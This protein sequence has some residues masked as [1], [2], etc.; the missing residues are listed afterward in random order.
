MAKRIV[1]IFAAILVLFPVLSIAQEVQFTATGKTVV[2][3]G[4]RFQVQYN[5]NA[6][7][8][9]FR[10]PDFTD[11]QVLTGPNTSTSS[12][13]QIINGQV[14]RETSYVFTYILQATKEG[15]FTIPAATIQYDG[16]KLSS[17]PLTV[18]VT[19]GAG[20]SG[21]AGSGSAS[22][23]DK[24]DVF[25]RAVVNNTT[26]YLGQE[27]ILTYKLYFN[28]QIVQHDGFQKISSFPGFWAKNLHDNQR[29][30]P[31]TKETYNGKVYNVAEVR[32]F[33]I[34]PQRTGE[35][36]IEPG[37]TN[38][39]V[40]V[41]SESRRKSSDP[42][43]D[44][45]FNDPF[46]N[47][48]Y[49]DVEEEVASNSLKINVKPLPPKNKPAGFS[50]AVG[51][52]SA[53]SEIDLTQVKTNEAINLKLTL[54]G[55]GNIQLIDA[56]DVKFPPDFEVYDPEVSSNIKTTVNGVS[57]TR[58]FQYLII[59]RNPGDFTIEPADFSYFDPAR[60]DYITVDMPEYNIN[61]ERGE[62]QAAD[63][64]YSGINQEDIQYIG[65]DIRHLRLPPYELRPIGSFFFRS[66]TYFFLLA[67]PLLVFIVVLIIWRKSVKRRSNIALMKNKKATK[68][69]R[70][71]L[72]LAYKFMKEGKENEFYVEISRALWGYLSDKLNIPRAELSMENV[73]ERL[74]KKSVNQETI[75][76]FITTLENTEYA[77][78]APGDKSENMERIYRE[79]LDIISKI[80]RE[81]K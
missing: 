69:A 59:P 67:G 32:K 16:R 41:K 48:R 71:R 24:A 78:F 33:A 39:T 8:T 81:L 20:R 13:V 50:G 9:N 21:Q 51:S 60:G 68:V 14:S 62:G 18:K 43:F 38:L 17:N 76:Q 12:S 45:F 72:N 3:V 61:V 11:F 15:T 19:K 77:R 42:F 54:R 7:G 36:T 65:Q 35:I 74:S 28:N 6:E 4:E 53:S 56:L 64:T 23:D 66:Q 29:D 5:I 22:A 34:F 52:F 26:P 2:R 46:F 55:K 73:K 25:L 79:A 70:K 10:G 49:Q 57:G 31:T 63:V 75:S 30:I 40:R 27:V 58:T 1:L 47:S 37:E 80:E 44:S